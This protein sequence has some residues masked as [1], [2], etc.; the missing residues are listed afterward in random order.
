MS[1]NRMATPVSV[2]TNKIS[3]LGDDASVSVSGNGNPNG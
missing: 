3:K 1:K 2:L